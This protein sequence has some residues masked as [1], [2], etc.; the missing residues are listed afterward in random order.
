MHDTYLWLK[1][2]H[3]IA[4]I[5]WM[6]GMLYLPRLYVY[7]AGVAVGSETDALLQVM[8]RRLMRAIMLPA[9]VLTWVLGLTLAIRLNAFSPANGLW[10]HFKFAL[11]VALSAIHGMLA[12]HRKSFAH[13]ANVRS[14]KY[15]KVLNESVT[16]ILVAIVILVVV[17]PV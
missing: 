3:I 7:H 5:C 6:A 17:K 8:E 12:K 15:F 10:M 9:M 11:V 4:V 14:A 1:A 16:V 13:G 2:A